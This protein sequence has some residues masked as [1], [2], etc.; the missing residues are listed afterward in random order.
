MRAFNRF[1]LFLFLISGICLQANAQVTNTLYFMEGV[2]QSNR[3]NPARQPAC[4]FYFGIPT[5]SPLNTVFTSSSLSWDDI[6]YPHPTEDSLITF[7][8]PQGDKEAFIKNLKPVNFVISEVGTGLFSMGFRTSVGFFSVDVAS[9]V[10]GSIYFPGDLMKLV[11]EGADEGRD[12]NMNGF[13]ADIS[14][15]EEI[16]L[17]WSGALGNNLHIGAR[18]KLLFGIGNLTTTSSDF[19][20]NTSEALWQIRSNMELKASLPFAEIRYDEDGMIEEIII[21]ED[22]RDLDPGAIARMAFNKGNFGLGFDLGVDYRPSDRWLLSASVL[23][24]G[25]IRWKDEIHEL[26]YNRDYDYDGT[27][28]DPFEFSDDNTFS[29]FI[30]STFSAIA[31]TLLDALEIGPGEKYSR[32]LN[33]KIYLGASWYATPG[34]SFGILS[35]TDFLKETIV[36]QV[37]ASANFRAGQ[38][39]NFSL[40]YSYMNSY[41]KNFGSG[42]SLKFGPLNVYAIS[43]NVLNMLLWPQESRS[44]NL[45]FGM[46]LIFGYKQFSAKANDRPLI[47]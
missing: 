16:A 3:I 7:L 15:F 24:L 18:A 40:S 34:I 44:A 35:R 23:D 46:N 19:S 45:W 11:L 38:M 12:Y 29:D 31:D 21:E 47:Y 27:E 17:G 43:D 4:G 13:G 41:F 2:P 26:S 32:R 6:I 20:L 22:I 30:D 9:R 10:D 1:I 36:E 33:T 37:T 14:G 25:Y 8:H 42:V 5:L 28:V 39:L